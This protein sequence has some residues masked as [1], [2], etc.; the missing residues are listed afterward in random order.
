MA[1]EQDHLDRMRSLIQ[2]V[3]NHD[4]A[5]LNEPWVGEVRKLPNAV[6]PV[7]LAELRRDQRH[8]GE[9]VETA[10]RTIEAVL[11]ERLAA[12]QIEAAEQ[13]SERARSLDERGRK[14]QIVGVIVAVVGVI[15][16]VVGVTVAIL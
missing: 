4:L 11:S 15:V 6:L 8:S 16:A 9:G 5:G 2:Q 12:Q 10:R 1:I 14:L 13:L 7:M 3:Q